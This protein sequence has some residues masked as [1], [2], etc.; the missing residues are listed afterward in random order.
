M[1]V[2]RILKDFYHY[3][4]L[5]KFQEKYRKTNQHNFTRAINIFSLN[6]VIVGKGTYGA[7]KIREFKIPKEQLV[8]GSYCSIANEVTFLLSGEHNY[9]RV[10][11]YPFKTKIL[12]ENAECVCKGKITIGD[13]VWIGYGATILS[14]V[15]IGKG[16]IIGAGTVVAKD[17]PPYAIY[18]NGKIL[19]YRFEE[20]IIDKLLKIDYSKL[21]EDKIKNNID[22]LYTNISKQNV[23]DIIQK[24]EI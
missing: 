21:T 15:T 4:K 8:I 7:I 9:M 6:K 1:I 11:T 19:K 12:E 2:V 24:L 3:V 16:A 13:D 23:D 20:E 14:G 10:S 18:V 17:V 5:V 22:I